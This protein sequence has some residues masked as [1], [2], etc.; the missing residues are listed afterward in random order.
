MP[1]LSEPLGLRKGLGSRLDILLATVVLLFLCLAFNGNSFWIDEGY[2]AYIASQHHVSDLVRSLRGSDSGDL[3]TAGYYLYLWAWAHLFGISEAA[4]RASNIP[5]LVLLVLSFRWISNKVFKS[6]FGWILCVLCPFLWTYLNESRVYFMLAALGSAAIA[7]CLISVTDRMESA[8][9]RAALACLLFLW[10][11]IV[12]DVV[13]LFLLPGLVFVVWSYGRASAWRIWRGPLLWVLPLYV[14]EGSY[15]LWTL[16]QPQTMNYDKFRLL[17]VALFGYELAG[18]QGIGP[19]RNELRLLGPHFTLRTLGQSGVLLALAAVSVMFLLIVVLFAQ[20]R[21]NRRLATI[22]LIAGVLSLTSLCLV[23]F[24]L[25]ER[26]LPRHAAA[27]LPVF[28]FALLALVSNP[29]KPFRKEFVTAAFVGA[30]WLV[31]DLRLSFD[32]RYEKDDFRGAVRSAMNAAHDPAT[33]LIWVGDFFTPNYYGLA[34][35]DWSGQLPVRLHE[36]H[37]NTGWPIRGNGIYASFFSESEIA[38]LLSKGPARQ[39]FIAITK[40]DLYDLRNAWRPFLS[41][42]A[43]QLTFPFSPFALYK[44]KST[45]H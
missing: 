18:L 29:V 10:V 15:I 5:F 7:A 2:S 36:L 39:T 43:E 35:E 41:Q 34:L 23:S 14:I 1:L 37:K 21:K 6:R 22:L 25:G 4:L 16:L 26:F 20:K 30:V 38:K 45:Y 8:Q 17:Y 12:T 9:I 3:Q 40:P 31:S 19:S 42:N 13:A 27:I 44:L 11:G 33:R 24:V 28:L 32:Q